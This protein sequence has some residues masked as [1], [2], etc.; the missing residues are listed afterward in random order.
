[1]PA[2]AWAEKIEQRLTKVR[3]AACSRPGRLAVHGAYTLVCS[4]AG[5]AAVLAAAAA[6]R[7]PAVLRLVP[8]LLR[9][10]TAAC[11]PAGRLALD[12]ALAKVCGAQPGALD[13]GLMMGGF[14]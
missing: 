10:R 13:F 3:S 11:T 5:W 1:M 7:S 4:K 6:S 14:K 2:P 9:A 8:V 12:R